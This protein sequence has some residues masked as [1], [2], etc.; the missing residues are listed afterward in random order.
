MSNLDWMEMFSAARCEYLRF[1]GSDHRPL[2]THFDQH[3]KKTKGMFRYDRRLSEKPEIQ[4]L[5][6]TS[7]KNSDTDSVLTK[8]NQVRR[9]LVE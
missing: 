4:K 6:E 9:R 5:V 1:E 7:W 8:L 2:L 3:L